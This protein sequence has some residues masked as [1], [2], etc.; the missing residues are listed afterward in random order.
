[1]ESFPRG[2]TAVTPVRTGP[3]TDLKLSVPGDQGGVAYGD[4]GNVCDGIEWTGRAVE[5]DAEVA[6]AGLCSWFVLWICGCDERGETDRKQY[7]AQASPH[8]F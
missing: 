4:A 2:R 6:G 1:M 7:A 8:D 5:G 3:F